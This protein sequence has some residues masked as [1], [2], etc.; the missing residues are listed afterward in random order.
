VHTS[1]AQIS[2]I[3]QDYTL[4]ALDEQTTGADPILFF[5]K[6]FEE[7]RIAQITE[8]N[9]MTLA[10]VSA[11]GKPHAR[12]VLLKGIE[13]NGFA[14]FTNYNSAKGQQISDNPFVALLFFWKE[15]ERQ[16]RVE[17]RIH[18]LSAEASDA[19]FHSR[20]AGS[21]LGAWASPQSEIIE[22]RNVLEHN[23]KVL[24][25]RYKDEVIPRPAHWGGYL[26]IPESIEFWQGRS[27]RMHDRILFTLGDGNQWTKSRLAP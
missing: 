18:K 14:F 23:Y 16:V 9:A 20:P 25:D 12:T 27:S 22:G 2:D 13:E 11:V 7:A 3:R 21:K 17:G 10:T 15:L 8:V 6:W 24:E 1:P 4:A 5:N 26:V 19:Y